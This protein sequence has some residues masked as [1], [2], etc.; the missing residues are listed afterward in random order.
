MPFLISNSPAPK[1]LILSSLLSLTIKIPPLITVLIWLLVS[2][3][4]VSEPLPV[5]S[6]TPPE[7]SPET[8]LF[9]PAVSILPTP[10]ML[11]AL[12]TVTP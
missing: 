10:V 4:N 9:L 3:V 12:S 5:F 2:A 1:E 8:V 11:I 7:I 6:R